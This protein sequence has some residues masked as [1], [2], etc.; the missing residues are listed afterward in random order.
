MP[1]PGTPDPGTLPGV[2]MVSLRREPAPR[3]RPGRTRSWPDVVA[4]VPGESQ[5][6]P[7]SRC[8]RTWVAT[9]AAATS[10][11]PTGTTER[12]HRLGWESSRTKEY[13]RFHRAALLRFFQKTME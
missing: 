10:P 11:I 13:V 12:G 6:R 8:A 9:A 3:I 1:R 2:I 7:R 4:A 5:G